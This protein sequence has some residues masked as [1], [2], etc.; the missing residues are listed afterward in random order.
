MLKY[1]RLARGH[2]HRGGGH[3][4]EAV[5]PPA[6]DRG[7]Q[8]RSRGGR[9]SGVPGSRPGVH[10]TVAVLFRATVVSMVPAAPLLPTTEPVSAAV[11]HRTGPVATV[12]VG[13]AGGR[14]RRRVIGVVVEADP[15]DA[16]PE[17]VV[18]AGAFDEHAA[19]QAPHPG[20]QPRPAIGHRGGPSSSSPCCVTAPV[21]LPPAD[22]RR[23]P[24]VV[25]RGRCR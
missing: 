6:D 17:V 5:A 23:D 24:G 9:A 21:W 10:G 14:R 1:G 13:P 11:A 16:D 25:A 8:G 7:G 12:V 15:A 4:R 19:E 22:D 2:R 18:G 20:P 3:G